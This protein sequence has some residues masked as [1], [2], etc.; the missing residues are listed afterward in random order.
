MDEQ[1]LTEWIVATEQWMQQTY[2]WMRDVDA[3]T[4]RTALVPTPEPPKFSD[5][6]AKPVVL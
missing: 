3:D 2:R 1:A 6:P 4:S 5:F